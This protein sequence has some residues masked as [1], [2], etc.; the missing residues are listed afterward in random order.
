MVSCGRRIMQNGF[1]R[2]RLRGLCCPLKLVAAWRRRLA[3]VVALAALSASPGWTAQ[4]AG[5]PEAPAVPVQTLR[6]VGGLAGVAQFWSQE[7]ARL[8]GGRYSASIVPFDRAGVPGADMLR[9]LELGVVPFGTFLVSLTGQ[10]P[11]YGAADLVGLN[12]DMA[13]L[14]TTVAAF[15]PYLERALREEHGVEA[16]A[17][18]VYPAQMLFCKQPIGQLADLVG[19]RVRVSSAGQADFVGALGA[20]PVHTPFSQIVSRLETGSIDCAI[21]GTMSGNTLGLPR[22]TSHLYALPFNWGMAIFGANGAAWNAL[23]EDL[24]ALLRREIPKLERAIWD[25]SERDTAQGLACNAGASGCK[26]G[27]PGAMVIVPATAQD[28]RL[29]QEI[30][31]KTVLPQWL[32]RCG[33]PCED[34]WKQTIGPAR[35]LAVTRP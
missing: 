5:A 13:S 8:S 16:L 2:A 33:A 6:V 22:L 31:T 24:R 21:T 10:Y 30:F 23:P 3:G 18:Y 27:K 26:D 1:M 17:I 4:A 15:R 25:E 12:P 35:R 20:T 19:R 29:S 11:Q 32:Q 34:I 14:R 7:L 28:R 9:L